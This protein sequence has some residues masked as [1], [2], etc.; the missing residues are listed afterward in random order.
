MCSVIF[1]ITQKLLYITP[2][3]LLSPRQDIQQKEKN[4]KKFW[5]T[6]IFYYFVLFEKSN[7]NK[8]EQTYINN[9]N[10]DTFIIII[11][12]KLIKL[13]Y[14]GFFSVCYTKYYFSKNADPKNQIFLFSRPTDHIFLLSCPLIKKL[15]W[16]NL[17]TFL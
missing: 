8:T 15:T 16:F 5:P 7:I 12:Y 14:A 3:N 13:F 9:H 1:V 11:N 17:M 6:G 10:Q 2:S 4:I